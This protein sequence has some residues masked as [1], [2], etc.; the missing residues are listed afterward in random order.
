MGQALSGEIEMHEVNVP[1]DVIDRTIERRAELH[2][3]A[4]FDPAAAA[5]VVVDMQ[6]FFIDR[7]PMAQNIV[8]N[9]NRLAAGVRAAGGSVIWV[10]MTVEEQDTRQWS[11][12]YRK[13][14]SPADTRAHLEH[15]QRDSAQWQVWHALDVQASDEIVEKR[16]FSAFIQGSS[17]LQARLQRKGIRTLLITG[18]VTNVCCESTARDAM[19]LDY[20]SIMVADGCAALT[21]EAHLASL[22][23]FQTIF[24]D[25]LTVD[26]LLAHLAA[27]PRAG[28][29]S[30]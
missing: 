20:E 3:L 26:D 27:G 14:L 16:R 1:Q 11:H 12:F 28:Q 19:M 29:A 8:A 13:L 2:P 22:C 24:G 5:L 25:V 18:T 10:V 15:L 23:N 9:I 17:D 4:D 6:G 7:V 21:D 30:G